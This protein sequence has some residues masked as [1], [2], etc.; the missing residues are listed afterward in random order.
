MSNEVAQ[1]ADGGL[2]VAP[3]II[4]SAASFMG[5]SL[6]SW[7][8]IGVM[9]MFDLYNTGLRDRPRCVGVI[10]KDDSGADRSPFLSGE[11]RVNINLLTSYPTGVTSTDSGFMGLHTS[12]D[13]GFLSVTNNTGSNQDIVISMR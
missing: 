13:N 10:M 1:A 11:N 6:E 4:V 5:V 12:K 9:T 2:R 7:M 8:Y 3:P